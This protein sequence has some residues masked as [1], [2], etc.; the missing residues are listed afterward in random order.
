MTWSSGETQT[1]RSRKWPQFRG[2]RRR[3]R[4]HACRCEA[5]Y[6]AKKVLVD[7]EERLVAIEAEVKK[8]AEAA[9]PLLEEGGERFLVANS[10]RSLAQAWR[11]HMKAEGLS[12]EALFA[13]VSGGAAGG[14][15]KEVLLPGV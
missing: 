12:H 15:T 9:A 10:A 1:W 8:A 3:A 6:L 13:K 2:F 14:I 11:D 5:K 4:A 7:V